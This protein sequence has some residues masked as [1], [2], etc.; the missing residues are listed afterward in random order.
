MPVPNQPK[1][2]RYGLDRTNQFRTGTSFDDIVRLA[3]F[4]AAL[5]R[6]TLSALEP[7]ELWL[8]NAVAHAVGK[9][10]PLLHLHLDDPSVIG[11]GM[12]SPFYAPSSLE[13][14][15]QWVENFDDKI[16]ASQE[17]F[18]GHHRERDIDLPVWA[19]IK[20]LEWGQLRRFFDF[21]PKELRETI[22]A[23]TGLT[24]AELG[25]W[26]RE[27]VYVRNICAHYSRFYN[28]VT[29]VPRVPADHSQMKWLS[30]FPPEIRDRTFSKLSMIQQLH[31]GITGA[32]HRGLTEVVAQFI[33]QP[34]AGHDLH[35]PDFPFPIAT[36]MG[37]PPHA[38][39]SRIWSGEAETL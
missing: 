3:H 29:T 19:A 5:R 34:F 32:V 1:P 23:P 2:N 20:T 35:N 8:R 11:S 38:L 12:R 6:T 21:L 28:R 18:V 7:I 36:A 14:Y 25:S 4:D 10:H 15:L 31:L 17:D 30:N 24:F 37:C 22:A 39:G 33:R 26:Q 9:V 16:G 27:L 13:K